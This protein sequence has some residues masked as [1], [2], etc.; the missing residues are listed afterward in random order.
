V[1]HDQSRNETGKSLF[2]HETP[3]SLAIRYGAKNQLAATML[4]DVRRGCDRRVGR[5]SIRSRRQSERRRESLTGSMVGGNKEAVDLKLKPRSL[6]A[7]GNR[8]LFLQLRQPDA[9]V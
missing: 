7:N 4:R 1:F 9:K 5:A 3:W 6:E 2:L 8:W